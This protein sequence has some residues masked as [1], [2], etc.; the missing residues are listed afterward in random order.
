MENTILNNLLTGN[1]KAFNDNIRNI[2][3]DKLSLRLE[4]AKNELA[5]SYFYESKEDVEFKERVNHS[6]NNGYPEDR[7]DAENEEDTKGGEFLVDLSFLEGNETEL[8]NFR[9]VG[10]SKN[11][12]TNRLNNFFGKGKFV[13]NDIKLSE[14]M[15]PEFNIN[16]SLNK[17][18]R[19]KA[20]GS[21]IKKV[22][23]KKKKQ[24]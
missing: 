14:E 10:T 7:P 2:L 9:V 17:E 22:L 18:L 11:D 6:D 19:G 3:Y 12:V 16:K 21:L 5:S 4:N 20:P 24:K 15:E 23:K 8:K 13:V 1:F